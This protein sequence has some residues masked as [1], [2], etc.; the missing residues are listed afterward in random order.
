M[1]D[2]L[3]PKAV[4][5]GA[6]RAQRFSRDGPSAFLERSTSHS[7]ATRGTSNGARC[8]GR[9]SSR[10]RAFFFRLPQVGSLSGLSHA[11]RSSQLLVFGPR[12][13]TGGGFGRAAIL[14]GAGGGGGGCTR[15]GGAGGTGLSSKS[16]Q[17]S[18]LSLLAGPAPRVVVALKSRAAPEGRC[19][20]VRH[21]ALQRACWEGF[22]TRW[23]HRAQTYRAALSWKLVSAIDQ[24]NTRRNTYGAYP[25]SYHG[26]NRTA[27]N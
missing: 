17:N 19:S 14:G 8:P 3:S 22:A 27:A 15:R 9:R 5:R 1:L 21:C 13:D 10:G 23:T 12:G 4:L 6:S 16:S 24:Q 20:K 18:S 25:T 26:S 11:F 2:S 7:L